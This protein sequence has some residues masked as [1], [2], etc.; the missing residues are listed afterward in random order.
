MHAC[1]PF[2]SQNKTKENE[3]INRQHGMQL[4]AVLLFLLPASALCCIP[5]AGIYSLV[6]EEGRKEAEEERRK[7]K[8][9]YLVCVPSCPLPS[10]RLL[11]FS[12]PTHLLHSPKLFFSPSLVHLFPSPHCAVWAFWR[13]GCHGFSTCEQVSCCVLSLCLSFCITSSL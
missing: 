13:I 1:T 6:E 2:G 9:I 12:Y 8:K 7:R 5:H 4:H 11:P 10:P 3:N